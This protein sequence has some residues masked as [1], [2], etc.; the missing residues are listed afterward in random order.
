VSESPASISRE[1]AAL[2]VLIHVSRVLSSASGPAEVLPAL[3]EVAVTHIGADAAAVVE[4]MASG[5]SRLSASAGL[6]AALQ[7]WV[8]DEDATA[9]EIGDSLIAASAGAF[10]L[11]VTL[12]LVSAGGVFGTLALLLKPG[13]RLDPAHLA[14]AEGL[15]DMTA[16]G[17]HRVTQLAELRRSF[18]ELRASRE[19]LRRTHKLRSLGQMAA[20]VSHDL[21]NILNPLS[22]H[23]QFLKR[24]IP[25]TSNEAQDSIAEMQQVLKRGLETLER[26]R[27]FSRQEP[28]TKIEEAD[29]NRMVA[30]AVEITR[31]RVR[32]SQRTS[33]IRLVTELGEPPIVAMRA[34]EIVSAL[35]NLAINAVDAMDGGGTIT[36]STGAEDGGGWVR[37]ADD[38]PGMPPDVEARVFEP[39]FTTKGEEGTGLGLAMV[40]AAVQRHGGRLSLVTAPGK[41]AAFTIWVPAAN[42]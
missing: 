42:R 1:K 29:L 35:V 39:F 28:S 26:L 33:S 21:R 38:G 20:G 36:F 18:T 9:P 10:D 22:L 30:E 8:P 31:P 41:G 2:D 3:A 37:V 4:V 16:T 12:P 34:A 6:P 24:A 32:S 23:L 7:G 25:K 11:A 40:Y 17:L 27:D 5:A 19:V 14:L 15:V 13:H